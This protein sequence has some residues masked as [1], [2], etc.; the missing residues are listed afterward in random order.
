MVATT[1]V[2]ADEFGRLEDDDVREVIDGDIVL[3]SPSGKI[4]MEVVG[5]IA[6]VLAVDVSTVTGMRLLAG[7]GG[8]AIR[9]NPDT[10]L[11]PD[12]GVMTYDQFRAMMH[13]GG[14]CSFQPPLISDRSAISNRPGS[15]YRTKAKYLHLEAR[16]AEVWWCGPNVRM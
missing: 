3:M 11:V 10:V 14:T 6:T 12:L 2:T 7:K 9:Q 1:L 8:F 16:I 5:Q 15:G 4:H 13:T